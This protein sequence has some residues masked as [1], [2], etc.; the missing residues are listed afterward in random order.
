MEGKTIFRLAGIIGLYFL[1]SSGSEKKSA[2]Y[3]EINNPVPAYSSRGSV[4]H[5]CTDDCSGHQAGYDWAESNDISDPDDCG[6]NSQSFIE[7]C[8]EYAEERGDER[9]GDSEG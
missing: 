9:E 1:F 7:G 6:G 5:D 4:Y 2:E 3:L 8:Q